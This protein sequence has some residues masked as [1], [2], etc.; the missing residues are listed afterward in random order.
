VIETRNGALRHAFSSVNEECNKQR[1]RNMSHMKKLALGV[2]TAAVLLSAAPAMAQVGFYAGRG[3]VGVELGAP[4]Y[5]DYGGCGPYNCGGYYD[6]YGGPNV[7]IHGGAWHGH[8]SWYG[9][10]R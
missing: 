1:S 9:H 5:Y 4:G 8:H 2:A 10:V 6:Y 3:G 7:V